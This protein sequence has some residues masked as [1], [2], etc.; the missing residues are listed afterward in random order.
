MARKFLKIDGKYIINNGKLVL[1]DPDASPDV[2]PDTPSATQSTLLILNESDC[3]VRYSINGEGQIS[4]TGIHLRKIDNL[5][6]LSVTVYKDGVFYSSTC[7]IWVNGELVHEN[8]NMINLSFNDPVDI[9]IT[10]VKNSLSSNFNITAN[11]NYDIRNFKTVN[12]SIAS[13]GQMLEGVSLDPEDNSILLVDGED[14]YDEVHVTATLVQVSDAGVDCIKVLCKGADID[15]KNNG[16]R[17]ATS[18]G[19]SVTAPN[20]EP[21][22]IKSGVTILGVTGTYEGDSNTPQITFDESTGTLTIND[23]VI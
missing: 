13:E 2:S 14:I 12:V 3:E 10:N 17:V 18:N 19:V 21:S 5:T 11:G 23:E 6:Q 9:V 7:D 15:I 16:N 22:N 1:F 8:Y 20:L 4:T